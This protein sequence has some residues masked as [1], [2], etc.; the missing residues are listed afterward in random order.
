MNSRFTTFI[1]LLIVIK[2]S[3]LAKSTLDFF[4]WNLYPYCREE[5]VSIVNFVTQIVKFFAHYIHPLQSFLISASRHNFLLN[6]DSYHPTSIPKSISY[7]KGTISPYKF[8]LSPHIIIIAIDS[9][10]QYHKFPI[11]VYNQNSHDLMWIV[12]FHNRDKHPH[13]N[14]NNWTQK[15]T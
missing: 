9:I 11:P 1:L 5:F 4:M 2:C 12:I 14:I 15:R 8:Q 13:F 6:I 3:K 7:S 10:E